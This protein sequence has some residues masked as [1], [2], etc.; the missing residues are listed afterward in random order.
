MKHS[1]KFT[2][3][4][5]SRYF[6]Q[7]AEGIEDIAVSEL[8]QL[9]AKEIKS[10]FHG[11]YFDADPATLYKINYFSRLCS[12]ILA[13]LLRFDCHSTKY[14]YKTAYKMNW[15]ILLSP[16]TSFAIDASTSHS[17]IK[18]SLYAAQ[19]LKDAIVD[20]FRQKYGK[21]PS[22]D[23]RNPDVRLHLHIEAN[24]ASIS[25]D[26]SGGSLHRR[27]YRKS[28]V[29]APMQEIV[30]AA[31]IHF[32]Q[33]DGSQ[34]LV[35]PMCGSGTL[36][37]EGLMSY[38]RIPAGWLRPHFGFEKMPEFDEK[39]WQKI[40]KG[41][42]KQIRPLPAGLISGSDMDPQALEAARRNLRFL[43]YG[44]EIKLDTK[45]YQLRRDLKDTFIISNPP[46]GIRLK[47]GNMAEFMQELGDFL[48]QHCTGSSAVLYFGNKQLIKNIGLRPSLKRPLMNG[49][50]DGILARY[51]MY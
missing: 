10:V 24:K 18:H 45:K 51:E 1:K 25:L 40:K 44:D 4:K 13:P 7:I 34:P 16:K 17:K 41:A 28:S 14:L 15:D 43:P 9:G 19:C 33:W 48:K 26:T 37:A 20:S 38:C 31:M 22:V 12:R 29:E 6:A 49:G 46:Y 5:T 30:A 35:D 36:L 32:S 50:L 23:T 47:K 21:R 27:G 42:K 11:I 39:L 2:Y 3:Q 8:D